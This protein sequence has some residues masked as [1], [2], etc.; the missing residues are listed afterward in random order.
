[1]SH[2]TNIH[3]TVSGLLSQPEY[4]RSATICH[5][6]NSVSSDDSINPLLFAQVH[7]S[8][9]G[10]AEHRVGHSTAPLELRVMDLVQEPTDI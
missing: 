4:S 2:L 7:Y 10:G 1:M 3:P 8:I 5:L 6:F 9:A